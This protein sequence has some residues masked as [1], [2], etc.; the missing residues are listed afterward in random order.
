[1]L[2]LNLGGE[3][4]ER[5]SIFSSFRELYNKKG[6]EIFRKEQGRNVGGWLC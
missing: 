2:S 1:M 5:G 6:L 3:G 4:Q